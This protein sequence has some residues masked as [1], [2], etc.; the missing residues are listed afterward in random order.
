MIL[1]AGISS[2]A[3]SYS[4][5]SN[6]NY[7]RNDMISGSTAG[8]YFARGD[9]SQTNPYVINQPIHLYNLAWLQDMGFFDKEETYFIIEADLDMSGWVIPPIGTTDHP[10]IG[11][12]DGFDQ[13]YSRNQ[14]SAAVI[15]N[16]KVSNSFSDFIRKPS[17]ATSE[18]IS[19]AKEVGF[20]GTFGKEGKSYEDGKEPTAKNFYLNDLEVSTS[21]NET[22][23]GMTAG[24][25]NGTLDNIGISDSKIT[26]K[27]STSYGSYTSNISDYTTVGYAEDKYKVNVTKRK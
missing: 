22:L 12:L 8:A 6:K 21:S 9:G 23:V 11:H 26:A 16:L 15:S 10:F 14:S 25:V 4:W 13:N 19:N 27:S 20:L 24:Y 2:V 18:T 17:K 5:F 1:S 7:I 3:F